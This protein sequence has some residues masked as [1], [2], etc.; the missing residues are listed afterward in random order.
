M[1]KT[2]LM[3]AALLCC[4]ATAWAYE[5]PTAGFS[6]QDKNP[7]YKMESS[8][9]YA[10]SGFGTNEFAKLAKQNGGSVHIVNHYNAAEMSQILGQNFTTANF[11]AEYE[12][13]ALLKRS[14]ID[15]R[16]VPTPMLDMKKY[17]SVKAEGALLLQQE[18]FAQRF[19]KLEPQL[20]IDKQGHKQFITQSYFYKQDKNLIAVDTSFL[21]ANDHLYLLT[22]VTTDNEYYAAKSEQADEKKTVTSK[23]KVVANEKAKLAPVQAKDLPAEVKQKLWQKH[24]KFVKGFKTFLPAQ[25]AQK[26]QL[27]DTANG[28]ALELPSDWVYGQVQFKEKAAKG[29]LTMAAPVENL[30]RIFS[31]IDYLGLYDALD[32]AEQQINDTAKAEAQKTELELPQ[33]D[34]KAQAKAEQEGR[35]VLKHFDAVLLSLSYTTRDKDFQDLFTSA[36]GSA[37]LADVFIKETLQSLKR[38]STADFALDSYN[39]KLYF[40]TSTI[41]AQINAKV[42]L[43]QNLSYES[44]LKLALNKTSGSALL[45]A[46]KPSFVTTENFNKS[47]AEWQF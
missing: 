22:T 32:V 41:N 19:G 2:A 43:L 33:L 20:R 7:F 8:K 40:T 15:L 3:A 30:E 17:Q 11:A 39:C 45:Y 21:S 6:V 28:K 26:L 16:T 29:C 12:K 5:N 25:G 44:L 38:N 31:D 47:L 35:K 13:L 1:K 37:P 27:K 4:T 24:L 10:F 14:K 36:L 18:L 46:H 23:E 9:L 42:T 34:P